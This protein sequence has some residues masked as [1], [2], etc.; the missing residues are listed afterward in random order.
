MEV[1]PKIG[2]T[3]ARGLR[4]ILRSDPEVILV[5]EIRDEETAQIAIQ[6]ALTGHVMLTTLHTNDAAERDRAAAQPRRRPDLLAER[7]QLHRLAAARPPALHPLQRPP[8][9]RREDGARPRRA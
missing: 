8:T 2:L 1:H 5:G 7:D 3:F 6:A 9:S 4:T